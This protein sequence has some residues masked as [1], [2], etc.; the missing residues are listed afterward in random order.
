MKKILLYAVIL[1]ALVGLSL[2]ANE[3]RVKKEAKRNPEAFAPSDAPLF[4]ARDA[5]DYTMPPAGGSPRM[6]P[7]EL[8]WMLREKLILDVMKEFAIYEPAVGKYNE[9]TRRYNDRSTSIGYVEGEMKTAIRRVEAAREEIVRDAIEMSLDVAMPG[10]IRAK[11]RSTQVWRAQMCMRVLGVYTRPPDGKMGDSV[12]YAVKIYQTR[13]G[14]AA[15]GR[16]DDAL[17]QQLKAAIAKKYAQQR[18]GFR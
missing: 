9:R 3:I 1:V 12:S 14:L 8:A 16:V 7:S 11:A 5:A 2:S 18:I 13:A 10:E 4:V 15:T 17:L 6:K